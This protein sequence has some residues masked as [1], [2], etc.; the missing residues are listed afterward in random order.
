M[1]LEDLSAPVNFGRLGTSMAVNCFGDGIFAPKNFE[2][3]DF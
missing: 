3:Y 1:A 2:T